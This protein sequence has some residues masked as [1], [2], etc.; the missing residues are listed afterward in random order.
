RMDKYGTQD[1]YEKSVIGAFKKQDFP[2][3]IIVVGKLLTGFDAPTNIVL[4]LTRQLKEHT[5]L[6]AIARVNRVHPGKDYGY[7]IDYFG[8]LENL[9]NAIQTYSGENMFDAEDLEGSW[10]NI[11]EEI[12]QLPQAH[13]EV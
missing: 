10:T 2:E 8:N 9:D 13:S 5:L 11:V 4:Y 6:Q 7:I 12:K 1:K 3:I